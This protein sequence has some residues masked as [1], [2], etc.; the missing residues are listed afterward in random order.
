M[1]F[2]IRWDRRVGVALACR[3]G[4]VVV[5]VWRVWVWLRFFGVALTLR[6]DVVAFPC[7]SSRIDGSEPGARQRRQ[8]GFTL[9]AEQGMARRSEVKLTVARWE[10]GLPP[11]HE[12]ANPSPLCRVSQRVGGVGL[13]LRRVTLW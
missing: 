11:G 7:V 8:G 10:G 3:C 6:C 1:R 2:G 5:T 12:A 4:N 13:T 9:L